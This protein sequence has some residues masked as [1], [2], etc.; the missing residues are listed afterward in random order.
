MLR[1]HPLTPDRLTALIDSGVII[2]SDSLGIKVVR[3]QDGTYLKYFRRKRVFNRELLAPAAVAFARNARHLSR[4]AIPT[5]D[6]VALHRIVGA[7]HTVA[8]YRPLPGRSLRELMREGATDLDLMY[9]LGVFIAPIHRLGIY[10]R[11]LHPGNVIISGREIGLIDLRD[12]R[13]H[14]WSLSR[15]A[16]R[17]NWG[18]LFRCP[19]EWSHLTGQVEELL[20]GYRQ[21]ADLPRREL[22]RLDWWL[23]GA[24]AGR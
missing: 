8:I 10:F 19:E 24:S 22:K 12:M 7:A 20:R 21:A 14:A 5:V 6:V 13:I 2:E 9:R 3:L 18:H 15:W 11:A 4:L 1:V 17:R 16:R 23:A